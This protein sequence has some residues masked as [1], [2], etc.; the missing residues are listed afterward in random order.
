MLLYR[1][2]RR[3]S[4]HLR[5]NATKKAVKTSL[6]KMVMQTSADGLQHGGRRTMLQLDV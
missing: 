4:L 6:N 5:V 1:I 3:T 2:G